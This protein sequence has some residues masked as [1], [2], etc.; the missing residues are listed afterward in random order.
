MAANV[1]QWER[2]KTLHCPIGSYLD[3]CE[4]G[5]VATLAPGLA[6][7]AMIPHL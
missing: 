2:R 7:A 4:V 3:V 1:D 6:P 5:V